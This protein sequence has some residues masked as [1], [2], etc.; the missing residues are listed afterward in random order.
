MVF[1]IIRWGGRRQRAASGLGILVALAVITGSC[2]SSGFLYVS[3][4]DRNAYFK[5]PAGWKYFDKREMLVAA[6]QS[7]SAAAN[8]QISWSIGF[9]AD[10]HPS[11]QHIL[12][13]D[14]APPHPVIR[15][16]VKTMPF[17]VQDQM[18][19][20]GMRNLVY[21]VDQLTQDNFLDMLSFA[22][23]T[24]PGGFHGIRM[25]YEVARLGLGNVSIDNEVIWT[26]QITLVD[27]SFTKLYNFVVRCETHCYRDNKTLIDQ[28]VD[29]WTVK[30]L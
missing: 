23:E 6:G 10:P 18:S 13:L 1:S 15:A 26:T 14:Y 25:T 11:T 22:P 4:S 28:I 19:I 9:D 21:P 5:V 3:S 12:K 8:K 16:E 30:E 7:L 2:S 29:S 17:L 20:K 27:A 24:L